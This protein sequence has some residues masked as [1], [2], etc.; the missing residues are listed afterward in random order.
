LPS[1]HLESRGIITTGII[2]EGPEQL[3]PELSPTW[4]SRHT[5]T[6]PACPRRRGWRC[7][8]QTLN[9]ALS[10]FSARQRPRRR[11]QRGRTV[12]QVDFCCRTGLLLAD[13]LFQDGFVSGARSWSCASRCSCV[14]GP[15]ASS[16]TLHIWAGVIR[17][18]RAAFVLLLEHS[19]E[20]LLWFRA[21]VLLWG[22]NWKEGLA[23]QILAERGC[24]GLHSLAQHM[25]QDWSHPGPSWEMFPTQLQPPMHHL[26]RASL[27]QHPRPGTCCPEP[28]SIV[29][30]LC[31]LTQGSIC[32]LSSPYP[33][34]GP[35]LCPARMLP[36]TPRAPKV[37]S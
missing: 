17:G 24:R 25:G 20:R 33:H 14:F 16:P 11:W 23:C 36:G 35:P 30:F 8:S 5:G 27:P 31:H 19:S 18:E 15:D 3:G 1:S 26:P 2:R 9:L 7:D 22:G 13:A 10:V 4:K 21:W 29:P 34:S 37:F 12:K 28:T 6:Y 32:G